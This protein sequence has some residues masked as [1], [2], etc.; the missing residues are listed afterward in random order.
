M[1]AVGQR[2]VF[3]YGRIRTRIQ[4]IH[5]FVVFKSIFTCFRFHRASKIK[6]REDSDVPNQV[7]P[8]TVMWGRLFMIRKDTLDGA[9][10]YR[11]YAEIRPLR[12]NL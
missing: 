10:Q 7:W 2:E 3:P 6:S 8:L 5:G 9:I 1:S 11:A 4:R 12:S